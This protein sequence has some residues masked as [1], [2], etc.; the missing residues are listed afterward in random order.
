MQRH[1]RTQRA[2]VLIEQERYQ[3]AEG[4]LRQALVADP[5]DAEAHAALAICLAGLEKYAEA[6][7]AAGMAIGLAPDEPFG[8]YA[9]AFVYQRRN[10][11][12]EAEKDIRQAIM[13]APERASLYSLLGVI[14]LDR[15]RW[16]EAADAAEQ[17]LRLD[18]EDADCTNVRARALVLL[19]RKVDAQDAIEA[20]LARHPEDATS[21]ANLGWT[22]IERG[23]YEKA[24]EHFRE[25]LRLEPNSE[26][27]RL[28]I[29]EALKA[30]RL[31]Y[32]IVLRYFLWIQKFSSR[33]Q[34]FIIIGAWVIYR[35]L[36]TVAAENPA[37]APW[38]YPFIG[39]YI[40]W[41]ISTWMAGP[42]FNLSLFLDRFGRLALSRDEKTT[43]M[44]VGGC[45][46]SALVCLVAWLVTGRAVLG[47][48]ALFSALLIPPVSRI[49]TC[50]S[51]WPRTAMV[52]LTVGL[53]VVGA[54]SLA[55]QVAGGE[56][57]Q[58]QVHQAMS[59][60]SVLLLLVFVIG[61]L[62]SQLAANALVSVRPRR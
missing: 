22:L 59:S 32:R 54:A 33:G 48:A 11:F 19:R 18:P 25:A 1:P 42:L 61:A 44:L 41:V 9:R 62:A 2:L 8:F 16:Q 58:D 39:L 28:G 36:R 43:A 17:G 21:H 49:Y 34:W 24:M 53:I 12:A 57:P 4:E 51:G 60:L 15:R 47:V 20:S 3:Q 10:W 50:A 27:A 56:D 52:L 6:T 55:F 38:L 23:Q 13:L 45:L 26:W 5:N 30:R 29:I 40:A 46:A 37:L 35:G 31:F 14:L 7:E